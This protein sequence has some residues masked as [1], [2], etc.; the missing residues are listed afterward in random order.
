MEK[1]LIIGGPGN[2]STSCISTLVEQ[3]YQ[4]AVLT[5]PI[6]FRKN[7]NGTVKF[8]IF[9][10]YEGVEM[11]E[12]FLSNNKLSSKIKFYFGDRNKPEIIRAVVDE[13]KP[14]FIADF[15][16]FESE[17]ARELTDI[18][19]GKV[20]HFVFVST[21]DVY[22]YPLSRIPMRETDAFNEPVSDYAKKKR[23]CED[24]FKNKFHEKKFPLTIVRPA[25]SFGPTFMLSFLSRVIEGK[26]LIPRLRRKMPVI[27]PSDGKALFHFGSAYNA[28]RI[29]AQILKSEN[30]ISNSYNCAHEEIYTQDDYIKLISSV[31]GIEPN[32][33]HIPA[34]YLLGLKSEEINN[35]L[36]LN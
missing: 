29:I 5:L 18:I 26:Y 16:C 32:I 31:I 33:V 15:V 24:I 10:T 23:A 11:P 19:Y 8:S 6:S 21:V 2:I 25:Y 27:V 7:A 20:T 22:G 1:I 35:G 36:R 14:D 17:Q 34:E 13:F 9:S 30:T 28:G 4:V 12:S 3:N